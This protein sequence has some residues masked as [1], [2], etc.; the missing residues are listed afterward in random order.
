MFLMEIMVPLLLVLGLALLANLVAASKDELLANLFDL[1]LVILNILL[2]LLGVLLL[3]I[4]PEF[5][6]LL[7]QNDIPA[8][9]LDAAGWVLLAIAAWS[10]LFCIR[11]FR[12]LLAR[13]ILLDPQSPVHTVALILA[14]YLAG[15]TLF[16]LTQDIVAELVNNGVIVTIADVVLQQVAFVLVAFAGAGYLTRRNIKEMSQRLGLVQPSASQ[17]MLGLASIGVLLVLQW[18]VGSVWLL[19]D[20]QQAELVGELNDALLSGFD[21]FSE[22]FILALASGIGEEILFRGALQPVF[23]IVLTSIL[24]A[25]VHVQYGLTPITIAVFLLGLILGILRKQTNTTVTIIVHFGYNF[26]LG[27]MA[28]LAIYLQ[29]LIG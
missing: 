18:A 19:V 9:N 12:R 4:P 26:I 16:A 15:N 21:S 8:I 17:I 14:G 10:I 7:V 13:L 22:W 29:E 5:S 11:P 2:L 6:S 24:F 23:G 28:L 25:V 20:P 1:G 3:I 27:M